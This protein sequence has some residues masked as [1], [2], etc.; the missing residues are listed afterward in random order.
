MVLFLNGQPVQGDERRLEAAGIGDGEMLALVVQEARPNP[1]RHTAP[2]QR[3]ASAGNTRS[4]DEIET[5]RLSLLGNEEALRNLRETRPDMWKATGDPAEWNRAYTALQREQ[6]QQARE[7]EEQMRLLDQDPFNV[8]AQQK[9]EEMIRQERVA[10]N[11]EYAYE[12]TP[13]GEFER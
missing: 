6:Q 13:E 9:I 12:H 1:P 10:E 8:E 3:N 7:R 11:M 4:D 2:A 5:L